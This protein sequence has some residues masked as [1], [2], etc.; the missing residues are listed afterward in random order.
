MRYYTTC[1]I[2][3]VMAA[4]ITTSAQHRS[5]VARVDRNPQPLG[6]RASD[7]EP[8]VVCERELFIASQSER[9]LDSLAD[10]TANPTRRFI[11]HELGHTLGL[12]TVAPARN[13]SDSQKRAWIL[14]AK[15]EASGQPT[16]SKSGISLTR[17]FSF[18]LATPLP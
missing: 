4:S 7:V 13:K 9:F 3:I 6:A 10:A 15:D 5:G 18:R 14:G 1:L 16:A 2:V 8:P 12:R 17:F 11:A